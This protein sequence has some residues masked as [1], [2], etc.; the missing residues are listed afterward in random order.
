M[1]TIKHMPLWGWV[2][3]LSGILILLYISYLR[4]QPKISINGTEF[5]IELA[6]TPEAR[7][8]G[9]S[10][11]PSL[12]D[13]TGLLFIMPNTSE[14]QFW[15]KDMNFPI[16]FI[17]IDTRTIVD[18]TENVAPNATNL[19]STVVKPKVSANLVLEVPAGSVKKYGIQIG[20]T[21][22]FKL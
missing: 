10:G 9:L 1:H 16:D 15:M 12:R 21:V 14:H 13:K 5:H 11:R 18:I 6:V 22:R 20:Q 19:L 3:G 4:M 7:E 17:W 2:M 8:I